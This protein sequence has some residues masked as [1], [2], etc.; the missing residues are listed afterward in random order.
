MLIKYMKFVESGASLVVM[1][2]GRLQRT[3]ALLWTLH[4]PVQWQ[5]QL[6]Q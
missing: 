5:Q 1:A 3:V 4:K 6:L 2:F